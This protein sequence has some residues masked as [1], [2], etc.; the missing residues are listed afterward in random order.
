MKIYLT[1]HRLNFRKLLLG[2]WL[3]LL[4]CNTSFAQWNAESCAR[5]RTLP[6]SGYT[7]FSP[8]LLSSEKEIR[9]H[10]ENYFSTK[11]LNLFQIES[12]ILDQNIKLG[13]S[14]KQFGYQHYNVTSLGVSS[15]IKLSERWILGCNL[16]SSLFNTTKMEGKDHHLSFVCSIDAMCKIKN[17]HYFYGKTEHSFYHSVISSPYHDRIS[18][19]YQN[20]QVSCIKW[21][22]EVNLWDYHKPTIHMGFEYQIKEFFIRLGEAGLPLIPTYGLGYKKKHWRFN[23]SAVWQTTIGH[24]FSCDICYQLTK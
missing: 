22:A 11:E 19:G 9:L 6:M 4:F 24:S 14:I 17:E 10:H 15:A 16:H 21:I 12:I 18:L 8:S 13:G 2:F 23:F 20:C 3:N 1:C 5:G 7:S